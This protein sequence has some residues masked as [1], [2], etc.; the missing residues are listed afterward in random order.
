MKRCPE[1]RRDYYDETL[2][3]CLDDGTR[4]LD[5]PS[6]AEPG[7]AASGYLSEEFPTAL[8][9]DSSKDSETAQTAVLPSADSNFLGSPNKSGAALHHASPKASLIAG[10][11]GVIV[12]TALG[13]GSFL[14]YGKPW[15]KPVGSIAVMPFLN[16]SGNAELEY[17]SDGMT[18]SLIGSLSQ[19]PDL[20]VKARSSV[21]RYKGTDRSTS[22]IGKELAV[23]AVLIGRIVQRGQEL[24]LYV[25]LVDAATEN[26]LWTHSYNKVA[27]NLVTIQTDIA[28]DVADKLQLRL[29]G[30]EQEK[31]EKNYSDNAEAYRLYLLGRFHWGK[32][33]NAD[34]YKAIDFYNGAAKLD[35]NYALAYAGL[36]DAYAILP[37][38]DQSVDSVETQ[39]RSREYSLKAL[40]LD[41]ESAEAHTSYAMTLQSLDLDYVRAEISF[42]RALELDPRNSRAHAFYGTLLMCLG[43][44]P[45]AESHLLR[46]IELEP[47][48]TTA[49]R[50]YSAYLYVVGRLDESEKQAR[51]TLEMDP[52]W[53]VGYF[54]LAN[55]LQLQ[56]R[57][58][59]AAE[60]YAR[61]REVHGDL[62]EA[63][64]MREVFKTGGWRGFVLAS[65]E[66]KWIE[67]FRIRY[68]QAT[69]FASIGEKDTA[70]L[71][72]E[73][74]IDEREGFVSL[75]RVDPR[76]ESL[77]GDPRFDE[78]VKKAGFR[79]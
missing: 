76:L 16:E 49:N 30:T 57:Y 32:R 67:G 59:E 71:M 9:T 65:E 43:R 63:A 58:S 23:D 42:K 61:S 52:A 7:T 37:G 40:A 11:I 73:Q 38:Y 22:E 31:V 54:N 12:V 44:F 70:L 18:E 36:A 72:L 69:R 55:V 4:L 29:T 24:T 35:P 28:K 19:I 6:A 64:A 74:A 47:T 3:Y 45:E 15:A 10:A 62:A 77:R 66:R 53:Q 13:I 33:T 56:G 79:N 25:E 75:I 34:L 39:M 60:S 5:G 14:Y 51:K 26:S 1:C 8:F 48:S 27:T 21:F 50:M 41:D 2:L 17:L 20:N 78:L 68:V 46:S